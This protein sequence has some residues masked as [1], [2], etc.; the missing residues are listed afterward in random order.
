MTAMALHR[1]DLRALSCI[2]GL[3]EM[4]IKTVIDRSA[5]EVKRGGSY[6]VD[7]HAFRVALQSARPDTLA[8]L[9]KR[10]AAGIPLESRWMSL[11]K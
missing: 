1:N 4:P 6:A 2:L 3:A 5:E 7:D 11:R 8:I 10:T 9:I